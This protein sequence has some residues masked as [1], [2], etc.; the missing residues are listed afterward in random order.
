MVDNPITN[1]TAFFG[2]AEFDP[3]KFETTNRLVTASLYTTINGYDYLAE[4]EKTITVNID[5]LGE[6]EYS[7]GN[8]HYNYHSQSYS[9]RGTYV[10]TDRTATASGS[11]SGDLSMDLGS[12]AYGYLHNTRSGTV[13]VTN[14]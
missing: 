6:G 14:Y 10:G 2:Y 7:T 3:A 4:S 12:S 9:C 11:I 13:Y 1:Q 8:S 5:W